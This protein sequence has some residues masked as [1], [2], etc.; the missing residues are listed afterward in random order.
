MPFDSAEAQQLNK[1]I[2]ETIYYH[3]LKAFSGLAT[4]VGSYKTY[5]GSQVS[6]GIFQI[7]TWNVT[8][9][10][11][12]NRAVLRDMISKDGVRNSFL[13]APMPTASTSQILGN[14]ECIEPYISNIYS[15]RVLRC[16][17]KSSHKVCFWLGLLGLHSVEF[18]LVN[19]H[20]LHEV[21]DM[22]FWTPTLKTKLINENGSTV[23]VAEIPDDLKAIYSFSSHFFVFSLTTLSRYRDLFSFAKQNRTVWEIKQRTKVDMAVVALL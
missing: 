8:P 19:K 20:L 17:I 5:E 2:F 9:S 18:V 7:N 15:C 6:K 1:D 11:Q 22:G 10:D 4:R 23:N 14:N 13:V 21:I 16:V 12:R 3:A